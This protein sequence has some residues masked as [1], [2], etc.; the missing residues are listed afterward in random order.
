MKYVSVILPLA[1]N[2]VLTYSVPDENAADV[3]VGGRVVVPVGKKKLYTGI[4]SEVFDD[5]DDDIEIKEIVSFLD[6]NPVVTKPQ[7]MLWKWIADY[8]I[9]SQGEVMKAALPAGLKMESETLVAANEDFMEDADEPLKK[10]EL[11]VMENLSTSKQISIEDLSRLIK[12]KNLLPTMQSLLA[13]GAITL[14]EQL[15]DGY[16]PKYESYVTVSDRL[17]DN[18]TM[19][20]TAAELER[21]PKQLELLLKFL[22]MSSFYVKGERKEVS[23]KDLLAKADASPAVLQGLVKKD[24]FRIYDKEVG[25]IDN[26][27]Y[28]NV[29]DRYPLTD[30]QKKAY[31][32]IVSNFQQ[33][34]VVLLHGVTSCGKTEIYIKLIDEAL[35]SGKQA[36]FLLPEIALTTQLTTRLRRVFGEQLGIYHSK[37]SDNERVEVWQNMLSPEKEYKVILGVRS[38]IFLPFRNLGIV[39]V[40]EEH[41]NTYKQYDPAPR[42]HARNA[43]MVLAKMHG[44]KVLLGSATPSIESYYH[45]TQSKK[46]GFVELLTRFADIQLPEIKVVDVKTE[47]LHKTMTGMFSKQLIDEMTRAISNHEQIILFQNRRGYSPFIECRSCA[48]VPRCKYCDVSLTLH[49]NDDSLVCHY[50]GYTIPV[51]QFCPSCG[52]PTLSSRGF[53]TEK[54]EEEITKIFPSAKVARLDL[55]VAKSRKSYESIISDF[56]RGKTDIL[57]GTQ[58]ISKGLDFEKVRVVGILSADQMLHYPDFRSHE[59]AFQLISQVGGRAGRHGRR[60]LVVLQTTDVKHPVIDQVCQNSYR[61]MYLS[62]LNERTAFRYPPFYRLIN[63]M[64]KGKDEAKTEAAAYDL[65]NVLRSHF[66]QFV[67]GPDLPVVTRIQTLHI[68]KI[69]IK[70]DA[71][72]NVAPSKMIMKQCVDNLLLHHKG[73]F[74]QIDVDPM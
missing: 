15:K 16:K 32:E 59:R 38:S 69:M 66:G 71:N 47:R 33:K 68:R 72:S 12:V 34:D 9:C 41:E 29:V 39:I 50:C 49:R 10:T 23:K 3:I 43:A 31:D 46:Y 36:L 67:Y 63:L 61:S 24:I 30:A 8:Y 18:E 42:Y 35:A 28:A 45:A 21:S 54:A 11:A 2:R 14:N 48:Y 27:K 51:P 22:S 52:N 44:A 55:D 65:A 53:G 57:V 1:L 13:K 17:L 6:V 73:V 7:L 40:D 5:Y 20:K 19:N 4:V 64:V 62:Q 74:V 58:M 60:G 26:S 70:L 56:E 25:R 37:F